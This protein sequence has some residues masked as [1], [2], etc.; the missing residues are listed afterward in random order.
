MSSPL[1]HS[2]KGSQYLTFTNNVKC[3][4]IK[5]LS[6]QIKQKGKLEIVKTTLN[7]YK[8]I[9]TEKS[10]FTSKNRGLWN[11]KIY[12]HTSIHGTKGEFYFPN[13]RGYE[14]T[15]KGQRP[16]QQVTTLNKNFD[17]R[18]QKETKIRQIKTKESHITN[19][20]LDIKADS[21]RRNRMRI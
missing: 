8:G 14:E 5:Y 18:I 9:F 12:S 20:I 10:K 6:F 15:D 16:P 13:Q 17:S 11:Q 7:K 19:V 4:F 3:V 1:I 2:C 21:Q